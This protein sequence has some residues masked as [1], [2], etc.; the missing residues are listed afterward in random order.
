MAFVTRQRDSHSEWE[1]YKTQYIWN[2]SV[3]VGQ[4]WVKASFTSCRIK[5]QKLA[6][7]Q[8]IML[9][10]CVLFRQDM[11]YIESVIDTCNQHL[12]ICKQGFVIVAIPYPY[13]R[14]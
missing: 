14:I 4:R 5:N 2:G 7:H 12:Y 3:V 6:I 9:P 10:I 1:A 8:V 11:N 13:I